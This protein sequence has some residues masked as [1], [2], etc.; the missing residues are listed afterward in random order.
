MANITWF[1]KAVQTGPKFRQIHPPSLQLSSISVIKHLRLD[2]HLLTTTFHTRSPVGMTTTELSG[3]KWCSFRTRSG[4][5]MNCQ[6]DDGI[7]SFSI[8]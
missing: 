6:E 3:D 7:C 2:G 4:L 5:P 8:P 1:C